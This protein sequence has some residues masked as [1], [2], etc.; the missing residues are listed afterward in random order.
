MGATGLGSSQ[1]LKVRL[2]NELELKIKYSKG[3]QLL[4]N[5]R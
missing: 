3:N 2:E 5:Y 1:M 4:R